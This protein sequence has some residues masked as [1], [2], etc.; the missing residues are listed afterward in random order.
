M[1]AAGDDENNLIRNENQLSIST[2]RSLFVLVQLLPITYELISYFLINR[3]ENIRFRQIANMLSIACIILSIYTSKNYFGPR[4]VGIKWNFSC[5]SSGLFG[6]DFDD[7]I[8]MTQNENSTLFWSLSSLPILFWILDSI[9]WITEKEF[10]GLLFTFT[11]LFLICSNVLIYLKANSELSEIAEKELRNVLINEG[12]A[13]EF[14][15]LNEQQ[16]LENI[17]KEEEEKI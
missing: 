3:S 4:L 2:A 10:S 9:F 12:G 11:A 14:R 6:F 13:E 16:T 1:S 5:N 7:R 17:S 15:E 8:T